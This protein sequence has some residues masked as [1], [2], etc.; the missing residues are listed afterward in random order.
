MCDKLIKEAINFVDKNGTLPEI[1]D[2]KVSKDEAN[3]F[4][5]SQAYAE[6]K[7][8]RNKFTKERKEG[9][10]TLAN[11]YRWYKA[12]KQ[13]CAYCGISQ[14]DL[15]ALLKLN[16]KDKQKPLYSKKRGFT[17]TLQIERTNPNKAYDERNCKLICTLCNNTKSDMINEANFKKYFAPATRDF[18]NDLKSGKIA[19]QF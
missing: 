9:F 15:K 19:N 6:L 8:I 1:R 4:K 17:A 11:F 5:K 16:D 13:E 10:K 2:F 18:L 7:A 12:Q 14:A 3:A